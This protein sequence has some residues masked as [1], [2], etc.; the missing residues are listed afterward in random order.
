MAKPFVLPPVCQN[1]A[2]AAPGTHYEIE[3]RER[4]PPLR[5]GF[6][7]CRVVAVAPDGKRATALLTAVKDGLQAAFAAD[8]ARLGGHSP[9]EQ[10]RLL[11]TLQFSFGHT[12]SEVPEAA[13]APTTAPPAAEPLTHDLF[14]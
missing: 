6:V 4:L 8:I 13:P 3:W 12:G 14:A 9:V 5:E 2:L 10:R 1:V 11:H 7:P